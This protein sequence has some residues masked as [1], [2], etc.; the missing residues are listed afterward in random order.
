MNA[1]S[2]INLFRTLANDK[3]EPYF[4]SDE[5]VLEWL[6]DGQQE[7]VLRG[8]LLYE[9]SDPDMTIIN[10]QAGHAEYPLHELMYE[11][12]YLALSLDGNTERN[13]LCLLSHEEASRHIREWREQ[14][15]EPTIAM[16]GD[17]TITLIPT[18]QGNGTLHINGYRLP[19]RIE[20]LDDEPEI[21][22]AHHRHLLQWALYQAFSIPDAEM[23]DPNRSE[24]ARINFER[25]FGLPVDSDWRR[26][27]REDTPHTIKPF[28]I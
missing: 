28:W 11:L 3:V 24:M 5:E 12:D 21:H 2:L 25:Y 10:V 22:S 6:N 26:T 20:F 17:K 18:P 4:W 7:A 23:F 1:A 9:H 14:T 16:Q 19:K 27:T 13:E 15:G 8:R